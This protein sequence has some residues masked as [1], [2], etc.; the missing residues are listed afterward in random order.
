MWDDIRLF[1]TELIGTFFLVFVATGVVIVN[2]VSGGVL[3]HMG[4]AIATGLVVMTVVYSVGDV[5]GAHINPAVTIGFWLAGRFPRSQVFPYIISQCLGAL[6]ASFILRL[7]FPEQA[8]LAL[9]V[10][11]EPVYQSFVM[12]F[13]MT[14]F[15]M[16]VILS[17]STGSM[18]K[19]IIAG[20][21][22]G[23]VIGL[24]VL[25]AGPISGASINPA[26]SLAPAAVVLNFS[27]LWVYLTAPFMGA[28]LA[29]PI[30]R[31]TFTK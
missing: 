30:Y 9:T 12:E 13:V 28:A 15:L 2:N 5:S 7:L 4:I 8:S 10:P 18:E 16:F 11:S 24:A 14:L 19:G 31:F 17:V 23:A 27:G 25:F 29:V 6:L 1:G 3:T 22:I 20:G 21:V 26:R